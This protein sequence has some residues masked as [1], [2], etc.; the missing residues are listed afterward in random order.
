MAEL[1]GVIKNYKRGVRTYAGNQAIVEVNGFND[2]GK[3]AQLSGKKVVWKSSAGKIL[4]GVITAPH[5]SRGAVRARF[6]TGIPGQAIGDKVKIVESLAGIKTA[7]TSA[8]KAKKQEK[9][10]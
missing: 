2:K 10:K 1:E 9:K 3:A 4:R 6:E 5:G 8:P 7:K